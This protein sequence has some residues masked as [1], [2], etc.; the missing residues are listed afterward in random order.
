MLRFVRDRIH[1][2]HKHISKPQLS[3]W[4]HHSKCPTVFRR[5]THQRASRISDR[6]HLNHISTR[7]LCYHKDYRAMRVTTQSDN[8]HMVCY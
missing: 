4:C 7:K 3:I 2:N 1:Q 8:L 6:L 5:F